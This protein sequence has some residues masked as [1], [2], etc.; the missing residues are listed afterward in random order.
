[1][2]YYCPFKQ[3]QQHVTETKTPFLSMCLLLLPLWAAPDNTACKK[4]NMAGVQSFEVRSGYIIAYKWFMTLSQG[5][6]VQNQESLQYGDLANSVRSEA[7]RK[8]N[9]KSSPVHV[10]Q[11]SHTLAHSPERRNNAAVPLLPSARCS[12]DCRAER[13]SS[14]SALTFRLVQS[15]QTSH[16]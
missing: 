1:M 7:L 9:A 13:V 6:C 3:R 12:T 16:A 14:L 8:L 10:T 11:H 2:F 4:K 5:R 15:A